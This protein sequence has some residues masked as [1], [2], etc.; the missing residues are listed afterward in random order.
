MV[1]YFV[2]NKGGSCEDGSII[3]D[4]EECKYACDTLDMLMGTLK[5]KKVCYLAK[6]GKCRQDGRYKI[7]ESTK[8]SP[9]CK[10]DG[11]FSLLYPSSYC[12][13]LDK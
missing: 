2:G 6:N 11:N 3:M 12:W 1:P 9:I 13:Y 7:G 10:K 5:D 8:I 4:K